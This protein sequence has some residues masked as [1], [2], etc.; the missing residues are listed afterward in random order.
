MTEPTRKSAADQGKALLEQHGLRVTEPRL[1]V[2]AALQ[3]EGKP[4]KAYDLIEK[5]STPGHEVKPPT[6]YRALEALETAGIIHRL[7]SLNAY[8]FCHD[9]NHGHAHDVVFAI[10]DNCDKVT[11]IEPEA[12]VKLSNALQKQ[13]FVP[14][15]QVFEVHG[16]CSDCKEE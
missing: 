6:V 1:A 9:H 8:M 13:G 16:A 5:L 11:E 2:L 14:S 3:A 15:R 4:I 10:C 12:D 7:E